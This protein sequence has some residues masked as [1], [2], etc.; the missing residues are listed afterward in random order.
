M[1]CTESKLDQTIPTNL[2]CL[3]GFH[4]P[5]RRDRN[6]HGGGCL[7]YVAN[8]FTFKQRPELQSDKYEHISI[9]VR[10]S[11]KMFSIN[12]FYR[13]PN[14]ENHTEFLEE[15]EQILSKLS[16]HKADTKIIASDL[17]FGN[18]YCKYP[19]LQ[20]KP[21]DASAPDLYSSYG[22]CQIIDIPTR[23]TNDTTSLI[24]LFFVSNTR[25]IACHGTL[26]KIANHEGIVVSNKNFY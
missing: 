18:C 25:N 16:Q 10:V 23:V 24:D 12:C 21:L 7:I 11:E 15:S 4:E 1:I 2:I 26:P 17:N 3:P 19:L 8:T 14:Y 9:D 22:F 5:V 20:P 6:R 13:P